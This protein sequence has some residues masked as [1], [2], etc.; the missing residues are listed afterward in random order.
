MMLALLWWSFLL[1][2]KNTQ[3]YQLEKQLYPTEIEQIESKYER[4]KI[5]IIGESVFF[6]LALIL[7]IYFINNAYSREVSTSKKQ[8]NFLLSV[9]HELKSPLSSIKLI[10]QTFQKRKL[11]E[12][13]NAELTS[14]ALSEVIRLEDMVNNLLLATKIDHHYQYNFEEQNIVKLIKERIKVSN[15][16]YPNRAIILDCEESLMAHVDK[17][18]FT[19]LLDNLIENAIKYS[20][21]EKEITISAEAENTQMSLRVADLGMGIPENEK[22]KVLEKFYRIGNENTRKSKGSGLGLYIVKEIVKKHQGKIQILNNKPQGTVIAIS[23]PIRI[24]SKA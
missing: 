14:N 15:I 8:N 22:T 13:Q 17:E 2:K 20:P 9:T 5:M 10:L 3:T 11:D 19:S 12:S 7:G 16:K 18:A 21:K 23:L 6:G 1:F 24:K 4:Q